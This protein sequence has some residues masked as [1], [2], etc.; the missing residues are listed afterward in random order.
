MHRGRQHT[1][2]WGSGAAAHALRVTAHAA[3]GFQAPRPAQVE[4]RCRS[5]R[6]IS[7]AELLPFEVIDAS[8]TEEEMARLAAASGDDKFV[9]VSQ[10]TRLD[11]R[12]ID[13]RT[14]AMQ[15]AFRLQSA[16]CQVCGAAGA[17]PARITRGQ[18]CCLT[19]AFCRSRCCLPAGHS[20]LPVLHGQSPLTHGV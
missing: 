3:V 12:W 10:E 4:V 7:R 6:C 9:A 17:A 20:L 14:P 1:Q 2:L 5:I 16:V 15:A 13:L 19:P 8:R 18:L 11:N